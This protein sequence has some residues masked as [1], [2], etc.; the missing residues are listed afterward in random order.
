MNRNLI[1]E[2]LK[3]LKYCIIANQVKIIKVQNITHFK[4][5][6]KNTKIKCTNYMLFKKLSNNPTKQ[7]DFRN[8]LLTK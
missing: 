1:K 7:S 4:Q 2:C 5:T 6:L 3:Q 8:K